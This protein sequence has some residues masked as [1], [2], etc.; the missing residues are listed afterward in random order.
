MP[1]RQ[2][3]ADKSGLSHLS[4]W[5]LILLKGWQSSQR[6]EPSVKG[7]VKSISFP[8]CG[9]QS[10]VDDEFNERRLLTGRRSWD[11]GREKNGRA[12]LLPSPKRQR[13]ANGERWMANS[14]WRV[15]VWKLGF[16]PDQKISAHQE[17][18]PPVFSAENF[19]SIRSSL[20][21]RA[22]ARPKKKKF[23]HSSSR[24]LQIIAE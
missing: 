13:M 8:C 7:M 19:R 22:P 23:R 21:G 2:I 20:E 1:R 4:F 10:I 17:M 6:S 11:E 24:A 5:R 14:E 18:C 3:F 9:L 16:L 15:V 12:R